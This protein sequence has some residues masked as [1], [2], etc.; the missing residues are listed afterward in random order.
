VCA[1][2]GFFFFGSSISGRPPSALS[3]TA[4]ALFFSLALSTKPTLTPVELKE[5]PDPRGSNQQPPKDMT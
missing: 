5:S 1:R 3:T 2:F 4:H